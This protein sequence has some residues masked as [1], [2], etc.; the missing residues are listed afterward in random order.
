MVD[1]SKVVFEFTLSLEEV[2]V[3]LQQRDVDICPEDFDGLDEVLYDRAWTW[4]CDNIDKE[5]R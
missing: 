1:K 5:G 2:E 3:M 4:V